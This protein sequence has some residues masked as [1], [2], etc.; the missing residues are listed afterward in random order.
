MH[1]H[2]IWG[3]HDYPSFLL[4][5]SIMYK[6]FILSKCHYFFSNHVVNHITKTQIGLDALIVCHDFGN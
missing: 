3:L 6:L 4:A 2:E 1:S 5:L